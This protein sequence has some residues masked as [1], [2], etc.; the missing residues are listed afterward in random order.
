VAGRRPTTP[1]PVSRVQTPQV[2]DPQTQQA[3][4][5]LSQAVKELQARAHAPPT[6]EVSVDLFTA[7]EDGIVP[8]SGGGTSNFLRADGTWAAPGGGGAVS[9]VTAGGSMVSV[10]PTTGNVVVDV[11]PANFTGIPQSAVTNLAADIAAKVSAGRIVS[12]TAPLSGGGDLSADRTLTVATNSTASA[13]VV[14]TAPNDTAKFWRGDAT[15]A[16]PSATALIPDSV[17]FGAG[18]A[19]ALHFDGTSTVAGLTP[20]SGVYTL[21]E[22][23]D[24]TDITVDSG[25][26]VITDNW[27]MFATGTFTNNGTV[28]NIGKSANVSTA[29]GAIL[30]RFYGQQISGAGGRSGANANGLAG[31][32]STAAPRSWTAAAAGNATVTGQG[33]S[34]GGAGVQTGGNGG[35]ITLQVNTTGAFLALNTLFGRVGSGLSSNV[36]CGSGGGGGAMTGWTSGVAFS[37]GGGGGGGPLFI[38]ARQIAGGGVFTCRGGNGGN[39]AVGTATG[40]GGGGGGGGGIIAVVYSTATGAWTVDADGGSG[41]TGGGSGADGNNGAAGTVFRINLSGDGT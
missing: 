7:A 15:W 23:I 19:G 12:T 20:S 32:T 18:S 36:T 35:A 24:A 34:G 22:D 31:T 17:Y 38:G 13:G 1:R 9:S 28:G 21:A 5:V 16:T 4:E 6:G 39:A 14:P 10:S 11:V 2:S 25:V 41:G 33:G 30:V 29:G 3:V 26:T 27:R 40:A 8:A 37:G